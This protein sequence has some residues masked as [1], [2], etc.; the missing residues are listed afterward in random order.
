M[1]LPADPFPPWNRWLAGGR[2]DFPARVEAVVL[3]ASC[4]DRRGH[5]YWDL[6]RTWLDQDH[7]VASRPVAGDPNWVALSEVGSLREPSPVALAVPGV[8]AFQDAAAV[9]IAVA[10]PNAD[11]FADGAD[12]E[13]AAA[14]A[15]GAVLEALLDHRG[16][17]YDAAAAVP[18]V[19]RDL[20]VE[21][22]SYAEDHAAEAVAHGDSVAAAHVVV[23]DPAF[24]YG[25]LDPPVAGL[26]DR[27]GAVALAPEPY[28]EDPEAVPVV[29]D[30]GYAARGTVRGSGKVVPL[31]SALE[32]EA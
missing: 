22:R 6:D 29:V 27:A 4:W 9:A 3:R 24:A 18:G 30:T 7:L 23:G 8:A 26:V 14:Y 28:A 25:R 5:P 2:L 10:V 12:P 21:V 31:D 20:A 15:V 11:P 19:L 17:A 16:L 32:A 13:D 1:D